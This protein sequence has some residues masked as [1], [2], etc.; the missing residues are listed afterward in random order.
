MSPH[1]DPSNLESALSRVRQHAEEHKLLPRQVRGLF[2]VGMVAAKA[3]RPRVVKALTG[4][5]TP[6]FRL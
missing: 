4:S 1:P 2:S 5:E 6:E 3:S